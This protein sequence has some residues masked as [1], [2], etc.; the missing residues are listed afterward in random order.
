MK[1]KLSSREITMKVRLIESSVT[2]CPLP[3]IPYD[4]SIQLTCK[5]LLNK[6]KKIQV[7]SDYVTIDTTESK[8]ILS[9]KGDTG[10][11]SAE[12]EKDMEDL[13][14]L[15]V[16]QNSTSTYSLEYSIPFLMTVTNLPIVLDY[17]TSKPIRITAKFSNIGDIQFYL[18]P[19][20]EN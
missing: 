18:A 1:L 11:I 20:V 19:R 3:K 2:D 13:Q 5:T 6:L 9:G 16:K 17:S 15:R 4:A 10:E 7:F 12:F 8:V 14:D